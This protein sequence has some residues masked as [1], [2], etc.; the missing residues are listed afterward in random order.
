MRPDLY[1]GI[2]IP[3]PA[4]DTFQ[5]ILRMQIQATL[6]VMTSS[7]EQPPCGPVRLPFPE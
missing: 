7:R 2:A 6:S 1:A 3:V 4:L 5:M